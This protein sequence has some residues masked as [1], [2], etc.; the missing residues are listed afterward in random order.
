MMQV[1]TLAKGLWPTSTYSIV[2]RAYNE[3]EP[4]IFSP[5]DLLQLG[6]LLYTYLVTLV[7]PASRDS[8]KACFNVG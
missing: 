6:L 5:D 1:E 4:S 2:L 8:G 3:S 7:P